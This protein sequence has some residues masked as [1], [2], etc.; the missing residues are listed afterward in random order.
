MSIKC[1]FCGFEGDFKLAS[2][3]WRFRFYIVKK[4]ECPRCKGIFNYYT[5][6]TPTGRRSVFIVRIRPRTKNIRRLQ[7]EKSSS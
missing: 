6:I 2:K 5:G 1:P 3:P 7:V 4:L